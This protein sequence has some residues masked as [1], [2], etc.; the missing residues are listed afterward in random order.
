MPKRIRWNCVFFHH[1]EHV[2]LLTTQKPAITGIHDFDFPQHLANNDLD[3]LVIDFH[4][5]QTVDVLNFLHQVFIQSFHTQQAQNIMRVRLAIDN[6]FTLLDTLTLEHDHMAPFR[7]QFLVVLTIVLGYHQPLFTLGVF[8]EA[9][10][11]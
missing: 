4:T 10:D 8:A 6:G 3:V 7:N 1:T 9:D 5:L 2:E 11:A